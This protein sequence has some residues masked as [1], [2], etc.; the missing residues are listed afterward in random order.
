MGTTDKPLRI[1]RSAQVLNR[2]SLSKSQ[3]QKLEQRNQFP[4]RIKLGEHASG[5]IESEIDAWIQ[6]RI[7]KS[8]SGTSV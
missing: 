6:A 2:V 1:L 4:K 8:R 5:W 3:V 7:A